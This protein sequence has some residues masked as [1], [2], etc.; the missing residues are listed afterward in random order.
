MSV[1]DKEE[2]FDL[3]DKIRNT[4]YPDGN[5]KIALNNL[6]KEYTEQP[7]KERERYQEQL[8]KNGKMKSNEDPTKILTKLDI[9]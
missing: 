9:I 4:N 2:S 5:V 7:D 3:V 8:D 1:I 6:E